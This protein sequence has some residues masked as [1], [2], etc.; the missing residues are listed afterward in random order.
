MAKRILL[1]GWVLWFVTGFSVVMFP[2]TEWNHEASQ[3]LWVL[4][5]A[6]VI[7][8]LA[9]GVL[10]TFRFASKLATPQAFK[11]I[12]VVGWVLLSFGALLA[13]RFPNADWNHALTLVLWM[14]SI[15]MVFATAAVV[16]PLAIRLI[17]SRPMPFPANEAQR[18]TI[19]TGNRWSRKLVF[20]LA[21][22]AIAVFVALLLTFIEHEIK[23]SPVYQTSVA[24]ACASTK[25]IEVIGQP[26]HEGWFTSGELTQFSDGRGIARLTIPLSGPKG[27]GVV[28][29]EAGR[30]AGSWRFSTLTFRAGRAPSIDLLADGQSQLRALRSQ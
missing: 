16:V 2:N 14:L 6:L 25:V 13:S 4:S 12:V 3:I 10:A 30:V 27:R 20:G 11:W 29:V 21:G 26:I 9:F 22:V 1:A 5:I 19:K 17:S 24:R 7:P 28:N 23:S 18:P 15:G 8:T